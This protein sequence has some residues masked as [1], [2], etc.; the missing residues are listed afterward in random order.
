ML[1]LTTTFAGLACEKPW[2]GSTSACRMQ[3]GCEMM[4]LITLPPS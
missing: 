4:R 3:E 1:A 2:T